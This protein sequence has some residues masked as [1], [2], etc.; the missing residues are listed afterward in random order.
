[1]SNTVIQLKKAGSSG[2]VP[3]SLANGEL[4]LDYF[5]GNLWFKA[6][7]SSYRLINPAGSGGGTPGGTSGQIQYNNGGAFAGFT[8]S[9]DATINTSTGAV[10]IAT[11]VG[12]SGSGGTKGLVPAPA[13]GD[14]AANKYLK[15]NG[16]WS[17][18][19]GP[20]PHVS[21]ED[22]KTSGTAPQTLTASTWNTRN[23]NTIVFDPMSL[24]TVSSNQF[25]LQA[26]TYVI[27]FSAGVYATNSGGINHKA[28][29][30]S[31][32]ASADVTFGSS[33]TSYNYN[34]NRSFGTARVTIAAATT[35]EIRHNVGA[36]AAGGVAI[37]LGTEVYTQVEI[38]KVG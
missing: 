23:L 15:A 27:K 36:T 5:T 35:Y 25:T 12:D 31:I 1:M 7:N 37:S 33:E 13:A 10:S 6:A 34:T 22:Q 28:K 17:T 38:T 16:T 20:G 18:V 26:G 14:A 30:Y 9:G 11:L 2:S 29:L 4:G 21:I 3:S 19:L 24:A 32:T 8:A